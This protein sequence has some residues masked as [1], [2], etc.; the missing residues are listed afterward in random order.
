[1]ELKSKALLTGTT[2]PLYVPIVL[3]RQGKE[4]FRGEKK[5]GKSEALKECETFI[6]GFLAGSKEKVS[7]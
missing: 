7:V 4:V 5:A 2:F 6:I 1:M 3:D